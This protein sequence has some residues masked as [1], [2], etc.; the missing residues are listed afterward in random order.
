M[1][2]STVT[3]PRYATR[4]ENGAWYVVDTATSELVAGFAGSA[5]GAEEAQKSADVYN[6]NNGRSQAAVEL[7]T[8]RKAHKLTQTQ[9]AA[10][11]GVHWLTVQRW[12]S[13]AQA[14][15]PYLHFALKYLEEHS[16]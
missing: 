11:L 9:L 15:P 12:E 2:S 14:V 16:S 7:R 1:T 3:L 5:A 4:R 8:W 10:T 13:G 6:R